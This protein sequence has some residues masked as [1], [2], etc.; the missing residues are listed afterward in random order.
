[1][2]STGKADPEA[3]GP[4]ISHGISHKLTRTARPQRGPR[5][6]PGAE[7]R[8]APGLQPPPSWR[9]VGAQELPIPPRH[10]RRTGFRQIPRPL[11]ICRPAAFSANGAPHS[12][13]MGRA[14]SPSEVTLSGNLGQRPRL[15]THKSRSPVGAPHFRTNETNRRDSGS[16]WHTCGCRNDHPAFLD[17]LWLVHFQC[18]MRTATP[19]HDSSR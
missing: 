2:E 7:P 3:P 5:G 11:R 13:P 15:P 6:Q 17:S 4:E 14:F 1:L 12:R 18:I 8:D 10:P 19:W 16:D 9:P